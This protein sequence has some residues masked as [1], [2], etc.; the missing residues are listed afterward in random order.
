MP[1]DQLYD[2]LSQVAEG[3][4]ILSFVSS[5]LFPL[6]VLIGWRLTTTRQRIILLGIYLLGWL[7]V[8]LLLSQTAAWWES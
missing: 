3:T 4:L 5:V 7:S 6:S 1:N 8:I 2:L